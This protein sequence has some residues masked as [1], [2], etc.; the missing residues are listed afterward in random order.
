MPY[1]IS[2]VCRCTTTGYVACIERLQI[3]NPR[4]QVRIYDS[5]LELVVEFEMQDHRE[6]NGLSMIQGESLDDDLVAVLH[7]RYDARKYVVYPRRNVIISTIASRAFINNHVLYVI[8]TRLCDFIKLPKMYGHCQRMIAYIIAFHYRM[9][10]P[11]D[12][13]KL[14]V[15]EHLHRCHIYDYALYCD[16]QASSSPKHERT[17]AP[18]QK[19]QSS[20]T[21][22]PPSFYQPSTIPYV[23]FS[24]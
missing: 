2:Y 7:T 24:L 1:T 18:M 11:L 15:L 8:P 19:C 3:Y 9:Y 22:T 17:I 14:I 6:F 4:D 21:Q 13:V 5:H 23:T 12:V 16:P 20:E 10:I